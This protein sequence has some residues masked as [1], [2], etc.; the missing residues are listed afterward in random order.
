MTIHFVMASPELP[1]HYTPGT[2][3]IRATDRT[4][5]TVQLDLRSTE[6]QGRAAWTELHTTLCD[7]PT[8]EKVAAWEAMIPSYGCGCRQGYQTLK[9]E[10]PFDYSGPDAFFLSTVHLHNAV[11]QKLIDAGDT[12]KRIVSIEEAR[13]LWNRPAP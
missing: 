3:V 8:P 13:T 1:V 9:A 5:R 4:Q 2:Q 6:E 11:N 7:D 10:H 12:R